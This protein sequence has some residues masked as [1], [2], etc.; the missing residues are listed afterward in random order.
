[1]SDFVVHFT[2]TKDGGDDHKT[3]MSIYASRQL[4]P[5]SAFGIG[6]KKAPA[7]SEQKAVCFSEIPP[8]EW[9][10]LVQRRETKYGIAFKKEFVISA[11]GGLI[12]YAWKDTPHWQTLQELMSAGSADPSNPIWRLTPMIDAPGEYGTKKYMFDWE[13]EWRHVGVMP[14]QEQDVAFLL[15]PGELHSAAN[16]FFIDA[17]ADNIGPAYFCPLVDPLWPRE[18]ILEAIE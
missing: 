10:R 14:F 8:G 2:T 16:S 1:M 11:G 5:R 7:A 12:W 17:K 13:R 3:M 4:K 6:T 9:D 15:I 18:R